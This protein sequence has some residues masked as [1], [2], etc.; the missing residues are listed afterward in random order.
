MLVNRDGLVG[1]MMA[2]GCLGCN[3]H[4]MIEFYIL[5]EVRKML[6]PTLEGKGN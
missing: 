5:I 1:D 6:Q 3:S 4:K 2:E